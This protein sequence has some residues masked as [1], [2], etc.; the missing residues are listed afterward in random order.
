MDGE[1]APAD[2][3]LDAI[4]YRFRNGDWLT[5]A[6]THPSLGGVAGAEGPGETRNYERLEFLGDRVLGLVIADMLFHRF[7][8]EREG[9]LARRHV[10]LVRRETLTQVAIELD[11][12][13][14]LR[15]SKG[16]ADAGGPQEPRD[17]C[18]LV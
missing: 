8:N 5:R 16:E 13:R 4:G 6:L 17:P 18:R 3:L 15:M 11:L 7:P 9:S 2:V 12:G 1:A 14:H 10:Q